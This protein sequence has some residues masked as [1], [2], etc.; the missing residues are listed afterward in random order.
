MLKKMEQEV[1]FHELIG[2]VDM[3]KMFPT[4]SSRKHHAII[5]MHVHVFELPT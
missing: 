5:K 3:S 4:R 2:G 1:L